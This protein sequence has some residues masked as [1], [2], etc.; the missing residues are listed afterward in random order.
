[1]KLSKEKLDIYEKNLQCLQDAA[2]ELMRRMK[3]HD[4]SFRREITDKK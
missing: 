2:D 4:Y 3:G 1:M